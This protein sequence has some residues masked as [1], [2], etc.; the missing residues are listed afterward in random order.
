MTQNT[1]YLEERV[2]LLRLQSVR[3]EKLETASRLGTIQTRFCALQQ[4]K[5]IVYDDGLQINLVFV[6]QILRAKL[7][8]QNDAISLPVDRYNTSTEA[9]LGHIHFR[10][11]RRES[12]QPL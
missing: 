7:D 11:C 3:T 2:L 6:V 12:G 5:H 8:L 10:I 1:T 9:Y 4:L